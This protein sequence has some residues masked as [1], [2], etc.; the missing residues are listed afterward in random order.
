MFYT[1][2][3]KATKQVLVSLAQSCSFLG[4]YIYSILGQSEE[5]P[6]SDK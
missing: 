5:A 2:K 3:T 6:S 4:N 1:N